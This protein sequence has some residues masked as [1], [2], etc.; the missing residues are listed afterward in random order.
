M[1]AR[2]SLAERNDL[3]VKG[4]GGRPW[5][6]LPIYLAFA[7]TGVGVALPGVLLPVLMAR[8]QLRDEQGGVLLLF[9]FLGSGLA[10][11][12]IRGSL[13]AT[14]GGGAVLTALSCWGFA[15]LSLKEFP[16][17][18][19]VFGL[20][21]GLVM[22]SISLVR[23]KQVKEPER[24]FIRLNLAWALGALV[25]PAL[26]VR[27]FKSGNTQPLLAGFGLFFVLVAV[28]VFTRSDVRVERQV[29]ALGM[30]KHWW[31][32]VTA[33]PL[34]LLMMAFLVTGIES[35]TSGWLST[36]ATRAS[37][38]V[39]VTIAAPSAMWAGL[40]LSRIFWSL[41]GVKLTGWRVTVGNVALVAASAV[42]LV[43]SGGGTLML[44]AAFGVGFGLGPVF[45]MLLIE[46]LKYRESGAVFLI[47][48][49][50]A[51]AIPWLTGAISQRMSSLRYGLAAPMVSAVLMLMLAV[52]YRARRRHGSVEA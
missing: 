33:I 13:R 1:E 45:P 23:R 21:M 38:R 30:R 7:A 12:L 34:A 42:M 36:Y 8:W 48:G 19:G 16:W 28:W 27:V 22:T 40:L 14:M 9:S 6:A 29:I 41:P 5:H 31:D 39:A 15:E 37:G 52:S 25:C 49:L 17:I 44:V 3:A 10:N 47:A 32:S 18:V 35:A 51:S 4:I 26:A 24:E 11:L 50:G 43:A 2:V 46:A 20:G